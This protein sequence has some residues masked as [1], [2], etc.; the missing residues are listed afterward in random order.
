M[1]DN[2][3]KENNQ[4][5]NSQKEA[6]LERNQEA[7]EGDFDILE[8]TM[9]DAIEFLNNT[10]PDAK[11]QF[12][13]REELTVPDNSY[14]DLDIE[15]VEKN[16]R[17]LQERMQKG[18]EGNESGE[19]L[20]RLMEDN[21]YQNLFVKLCYR[22]NQGERTDD[23][24]ERHRFVNE[25]LYGRISRDHFDAILKGQLEEIKRKTLSD[26]E[27][28]IRRELFERLPFEDL[29]AGKVAEP[30]DQLFERFGKICEEYLQYILRHIPEQEK[31][32]PQEVC[33]IANEIF[34]T[35]FA[36][37]GWKA[38][39]KAQKAFASV[40]QETRIF[41]VP[42][43][44]SK[45][46]FYFKDV[47]GLFAHEIG[48]HVVR[49]IPYQS[50][51]IKAFSRG[52]PGYIGFEEGL[53]NAVQH[54]ILHEKAPSGHLHYVSIGLA[55]FFHLN[56]REVYEIQWRIQRLLGKAN[57]MQCFDSV[58]RAFRGTGYL[59]NSK[60]I[61]YFE[62]YEKVWKFIEENME[63][64]DM[65]D[66]LFGLGKIDLTDAFWRD[67]AKSAKHWLTQ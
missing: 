32:T 36:G 24:I 44:R 42:G 19:V 10:N 18:F 41:N 67:A 5:V 6:S 37:K 8:E 22:Y 20:R 11:E 51:K 9:I 28:Q 12:I 2:C 46:E 49:S 29:R 60:D 33:N 55:V 47:K 48:V 14:G 61:A 4:K 27:E 26:E 43:K 65:M 7:M 62:G 52:I 66:E 35:E 58:Q 15:R 23:L 45:G 34:E 31:Y 53:A 16:L 13:S 1:T 57:K 50:C 54:S 64:A 38:E 21:L 3:I 17:I 25:I 40:N 63:K 30:S 56:F 59:V 39:V